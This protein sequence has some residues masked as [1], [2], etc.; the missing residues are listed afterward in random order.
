MDDFDFNKIFIHT[1][2]SI[3]NVFIVLHSSTGAEVD[4]VLEPVI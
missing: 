3:L 2:I 1:S 4:D